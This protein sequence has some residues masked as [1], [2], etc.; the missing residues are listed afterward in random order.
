M[1]EQPRFRA[2]LDF[3]RLRGEAGEVDPELARWWEELLRKP[4][5]TSAIAS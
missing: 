1:V 4:T 2:G 5:P 3:L